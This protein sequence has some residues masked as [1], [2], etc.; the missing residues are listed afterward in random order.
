MAW[1]S[2]TARL[3]QNVLGLEVVMPSLP[4]SRKVLRPCSQSWG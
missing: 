1:R 4:A 3:S 2:V